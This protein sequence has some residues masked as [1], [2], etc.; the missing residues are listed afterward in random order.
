MSIESYQVSL[1]N[2]RNDLEDLIH[3]RDVVIPELYKMPGHIIYN[4]EEEYKQSIL[5]GDPTEKLVKLK[6]DIIG[7]NERYESLTNQKNKII[8]IHDVHTLINEKLFS[9]EKLTTQIEDEKIKFVDS[10][11]NLYR[12]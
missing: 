8:G 3:V 5:N 9:I 11:K 1:N 10:L 6:R 12:S 2:H 4:L 7:Y